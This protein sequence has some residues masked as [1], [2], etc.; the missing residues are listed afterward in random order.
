M[1]SFLGWLKLQKRREDPVGDLANDVTRD[2]D[3]PRR[4]SDPEQLDDYLWSQ[5]A[6]DPARRALTRALAEYQ[7]YRRTLGGQKTFPTA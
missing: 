6:C 4:C 2:P 1:L 5:G 3:F 7:Q